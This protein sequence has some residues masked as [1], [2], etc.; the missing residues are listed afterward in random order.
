MQTSNESEGVSIGRGTLFW[1]RAERLSQRY[2]TVYLMRDGLNSKS[3]EPL[4]SILDEA[5]VRALDG[6]QGE[7]VAV[8]VTAR[9]STHPGDPERQISP[10]IP[11]VGQSFI[12]GSGTLFVEP[13]PVGG[14]SI[15]MAP[16]DK[17]KRFRDWLFIRP[18]YDAHEQTV[19]LVFMP[20]ARNTAKKI[21]A[22]R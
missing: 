8:I 2:G 20:D 19:E 15:G 5:K 1:D 21:G 13:N 4:V 22:S 11:K 9:E 14:V 7:L 18:L 6:R 12:L 17:D 16:P 3:H 10:R